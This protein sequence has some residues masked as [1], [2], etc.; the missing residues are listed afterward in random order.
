MAGKT[1]VPFTDANGS[2]LWIDNPVHKK[3]LEKSK[4]CLYL[5]EYIRN[6]LSI[7]IVIMLEDP[8]PIRE[9]AFTKDFSTGYTIRLLDTTKNK[10]EIEKVVSDI[11]TNFFN[12]IRS[13]IFNNDKGLKLRKLN[14]CC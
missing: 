6:L 13:K 3:F 4:F 2:G 12:T 11:C 14:I 9:R 1:C 10:T 7:E 5:Q 8:P